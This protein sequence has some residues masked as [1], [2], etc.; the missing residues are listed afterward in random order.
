MQAERAVEAG[1]HQ[2]AR[3]LLRDIV[4]IAK[5]HPGNVQLAG[6]I[7]NSALL[8]ERI[9][10]R[11]LA[12]ELHMLAAEADPDHWNVLQN[13][14]EFV[15]DERVS[16]LYP[17]VKSALER[18]A[19]EG[20]QHKPDR[21]AALAVNFGRLTGAPVGDVE[22]RVAEVLQGVVDDPGIVGLTRVIELFPDF[23]DS[24]RL[25]DL[26]RHVASAVTSDRH[27][28]VSLRLL[29][30]ALAQSDRAEDE[31]V[32]LDLYRFLLSSGLACLDPGERDDQELKHNAAALLANR[33]YKRAALVIW[34]RLY[35]VRPNDV[36]IRRSLAISLSNE[37]HGA[38]AE[39]VLQGHELPPISVEHE[40]LPTRFASHMS[41]WWES[42]P[43]GA[44]PSCGDFTAV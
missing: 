30:D 26:T 35:A 7:G 34:R 4:G 13:F 31:V 16:T 8:A 44:Y 18:L 23:V 29:A 24:N 33:G 36:K 39:A 38:E 20:R 15:I 12:L 19:T 10:D 37:G 32:A 2:E 1:Q 42:L 27:R 25:L 22:E 11:N 40:P 5:R 6:R 17:R 43:V 41:P 21:T 9:T 28:Y 3:H 14:A